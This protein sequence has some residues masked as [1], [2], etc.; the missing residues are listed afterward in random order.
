L[1]Q[2]WMKAAA[3]RGLASPIA[4]L[5]ATSRPRL[6]DYLNFVID[7]PETRQ[8]V[9]F[10]KASAG[11]RPSCMR[12][13]CARHG[14]AVLAIKSGATAQSQAAAASIPA[15]LPAITRRNLAMCERY[16]S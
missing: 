5:R 10:T 4:S 16:G 2:F 11:R 9:L 14:Q 3:E 7:D 6:A 8:V 12:P 15:L 1:I 13:A